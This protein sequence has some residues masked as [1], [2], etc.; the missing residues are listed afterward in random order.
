MIYG[1][2]SLVNRPPVGAVSFTGGDW[3][4]GFG[5]SAMQVA[6]LTPGSAIF[7][8]NNVTPTN[9]FGYV[10]IPN[11]GYT[12]QTSTNGTLWT[13]IATGPGA[14][15]Q[16][17]SAHV[18]SYGTTS[19]TGVLIHLTASYTDLGGAAEIVT[20]PTWNLIVGSGANGSAGN[21][22]LT[23]ADKS[24]GKGGTISDVIF[25]LNGNDSISGGLG[26]DRLFGSRGND[27]LNGGAGNDYLDGGEGANSL[28]DGAGDDTYLVN[29]AFDTVNETVAGSGGIDMVM[30]TISYTLTTNVEHLTLTGGN[31]NGTGNALANIIAGSSGAN[32][33]DGGSAGA[34]TLAG[35]LGDDTYIISHAGMT[36]NE[37][38]N[39]GTDTVSTTLATYR[40]ENNVENLTFTGAGAFTGNGN[41]LDNV[42]TGGGGIDML[43]GLAG[44]DTIS[45]GAGGADILTGGLGDDTYIIGHTGMTVAENVGEGVDT[46]STNLGSY[47]LGLNLENL[48]YTG[49]GAFSGTGN[50]LNNVITTASGSDVLNGGGSDDT[51]IGGTGRDSLTGGAG[52]DTF[53]FKTAAEAGYG[54]G[55]SSSTNAD[56]ITDFLAGT[57]RI[58]LSFI[59]ANTQVFGDQG[60]TWD[61]RLE[62]G[63]IRPAAGHIGYHYEG[64]FTVI[65]G[66]INTS[67]NGTDTT[68]D[69]QIKLAGNLVLHASD[70]IL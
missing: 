5:Q 1:I 68:V 38:L 20:S 32:T 56:L 22:T 55:T 53:V 11:S 23:G 62:T 51:L 4:S 49:T 39:A 60:F 50:M 65:D 25:G 54:T 35:G 29:S 28:A 70:F 36:V 61:N 14:N 26:D 21:N 8:P 41:A 24:D 9:P 18:L 34:D 43:Y 45:G 19:S 57:D 40:L 17:A 42:I 12:W 13:D 47:A 63:A 15:Q 30:S 52:S 33:L 16:N 64:A 27:T 46:V 67:R 69:F 66:N 48:T 2:E 31:I 37:A 10:A 6:T 3:M 7:D 59:D 58:D 44:N